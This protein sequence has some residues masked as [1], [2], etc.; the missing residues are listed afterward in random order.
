MDRAKILDKI[1]KCM[2]LSKSPN[3][4]EAA[5]AMRQAQKLMEKHGVSEAEVGL[6]SYAT[7]RVQVPIQ[8]NKKAPLA[9]VHLVNLIRAA[10]GV[11]AVL[12]TEVRVSDRSYVVSY[13]G[14][15]QSVALA[16]YTHTV[17]FRSMNSAWTKHLKDRPYLKSERGAR[18]GFQIGWIDSVRSTVIDFG[19]TD[20]ER[21]MLE[22]YKGQQFPVLV[23]GKVSKTA[24][25]AGAL[26]AGNAAAKGFALH[27]PMHGSETLKLGA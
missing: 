7:E 20:D 19:L 1:E 18:A 11:E 6:S 16:A 2:N 15:E 3:P 8:A 25:D 27:R 17:I 24:L 14:K 12:G 4:H 22:R 10:F 9:L 26:R 13:L 5:A 23:T 21:E